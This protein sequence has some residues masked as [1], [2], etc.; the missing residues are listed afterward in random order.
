ME[1][2]R[3]DLLTQVAVWYYEE[4]LNQADIAQRIDKS[5]S[6]VSRLLDQAREAGLVEVRVRHPL[7]TDA[8]LEQRLCQ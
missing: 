6:M 2:E 4:G 5:R 3:I 1:E 7:R 8:E